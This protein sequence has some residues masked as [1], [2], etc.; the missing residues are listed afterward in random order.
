MIIKRP[1]VENLSNS[2]FPPVPQLS[3]TTVQHSLG[4]RMNRG[5]TQDRD[6]CRLGHGRQQT[7]PASPFIARPL[8]PLPSPAEQVPGASS[9]CK[10][11]TAQLLWGQRLLMRRGEKAATC[12]SKCD[13]FTGRRHRGICH[14]CSAKTDDDL[15]GFPP[16]SRRKSITQ[17]AS[18]ATNEGDAGEPR[19][20]LGIL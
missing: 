7:L 13:S 12:L 4:G 20:L 10:T 17:R 18:A 11:V 8:T 9:R 15:S 5:G 6:R 16:H 3:E 2:I 14:R 19:R 1:V